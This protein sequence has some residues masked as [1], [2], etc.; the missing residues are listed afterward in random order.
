MRTFARSNDAVYAWIPTGPG[1]IAYSYD[2]LNRLTQA[3]GQAITHDS[4]GNLTGDGVSSYT[5]DVVNR[6]VSVTKG[7]V[8]VTLGYDPIGRLRSVAASGQTTRFLYSGD[9]LV[10]EYDNSGALLRRYVHGPGID[11]PLVWYE[12]ATASDRRWLHANPQGS[13]VAVTDASGAAVATFRYGPYGES[14]DMSGGRFQYTGQIA[15][16]EAGIYHYKARAYSPALGRFL[17]TDPIGYGDGLNL[18]AYAGNDPV[19]YR[20]PLGL[21]S[22]PSMAASGDN[23]LL[24]EVLVSGW[25]RGDPNVQV[26]SGPF[27]TGGLANQPINWVAVGG[28]AWNDARQGPIAPGFDDAGKEGEKPCV[29][30]PTA[31]GTDITSRGLTEIARENAQQA[32]ERKFDP[33]NLIWFRDQVRNGGP[34]DYKQFHPGLQD[35]GNYNYGYAGTAMGVSPDFL[36]QQAGRAQIEA[37][38]SRPEWGSP[39]PFG[40]FGGTPPY[41]DDPRDQEMIKRGISDQRNGC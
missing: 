30:P 38:T 7:G 40:L 23:N 11:E 18:Y 3:G 13:I 25:R 35:F 24:D 17:Q 6:L 41:G 22:E 19:N 1:S 4:R 26:N 29:G 20:D 39:G 27:L 31:P 5:Y 34:W 8:T 9:D 33:L 37:G 12:G 2:G 21:A 28:A 15:I 16:P 14:S 32:A 10:A 36:L